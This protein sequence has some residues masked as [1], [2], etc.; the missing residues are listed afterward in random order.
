MALQLCH[1]REHGTGIGGGRQS[2]SPTSKSFYCRV[3]NQQAE[4]MQ[5]GSKYHILKMNTVILNH[6]RTPK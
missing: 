1:L 6:I 5:S 2:N 4:E 3:P